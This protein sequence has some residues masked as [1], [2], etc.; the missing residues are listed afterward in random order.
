M[1]GLILAVM[2]ALALPGQIA[3]T[4][5]ESPHFELYTDGSKG[6]AADILEHFERV[7]SFFLQTI[8]PRETPG[9]PRVVVLNS[10]KTF[11]TFVERKSTI[12]YYLGLPHR[13]L[14]VVGPAGKGA[15]NQTITHEYLH[16]LVHQAGMRIPLWMNEGIAE[17]YSTLQ[18][19]GQKMRVG[20]PI[21]GHM[22][23]L[24]YDWL[25]I[26]Q[27]LKAESY[28]SEEHVG[29]F[30]SMSWAI[31]H[32]LLLEDDLR[33]KWTRF[34]AAMERGIP[35]EQ[36]LRQAYGLTP[37]QLEQHVQGYIRGKTVNVVEFNFKWEEWKGAPATR[38]A[39]A[40]E[41]GL[42]MVDLFL[43]GKDVAGAARHAERLAGEFPRE[44][45]PW[46]ALLTARMWERNKE[47]GAVAARE[48][49][50]RG[51]RNADLLALGASLGGAEARAMLDRA[52]TVDPEHFEGL[53]ELAALQL[54]AGEDGAA[55]ATLQRVR[56]LGAADAARYVRL[57]VYAAQRSGNE[58]AAEA[59]VK[60]F[61]AYAVSE[62]DKAEGE[63]RA[64]MM[65]RSVTGVLVEVGCSASGQVLHVDSGGV[66]AIPVDAGQ[67]LRVSGVEFDLHCGVMKRKPRV[68]V[69]LS[70]EG[71]ARAL[72]ILR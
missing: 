62:R 46:E 72:E 11:A 40:L 57:F 61:R 58:A 3:F 48:A 26:R 34:T 35:I 21:Q 8:N 29:P 18:P 14:I 39:T 32:M 55:F 37:Q 31:A 6:R 9:T 23:R 42:T 22:L 19:V 16:L 2:A 53:M 69:G 56:R 30:Y 38:P 54:Q 24:R 4:R 5:M 43:S 36:A 7:R 70:G 12:A 67:T 44:A 65:G 51:T 66:R 17:V 49:F 50:A 33:P 41:N 52:L 25:D 13:D 47:A 68:R 59:A 20:T 15:D 71:K 27:V 63:T 1:R 10:A 60:E 28:G 45:G 64:G